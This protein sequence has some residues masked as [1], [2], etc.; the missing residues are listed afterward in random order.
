MKPNR[1]PSQGQID[2]TTGRVTRIA[3]ER[4]QLMRK[5]HFQ[6][7]P[8]CVMCLARGRTT[9]A[10]ELDHIIALVNG[11]TNDPENLAGLCRWCH[12]KKTRI[13]MGW[14]PKPKIGADGW[15]EDFT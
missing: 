4:L 10:T 1:K 11:G 14:K 3:G 8:L 13:D 7:Q 6:L 9:V 2:P 5:R 12:I 15:P